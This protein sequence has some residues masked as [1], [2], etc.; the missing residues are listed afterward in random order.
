MI[1]AHR[2]ELGAQLADAFVHRCHHRQSLAT[3]LGQVDRRLREPRLWGLQRDV[4]GVVREVEEERLLG[5]GGTAIEEGQGGFGL[6]DHA[7]TIVGHEV[8]RVGERL[9]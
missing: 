1:L 8:W 4:W 9:P 2:L 6:H 7:E 5:L 3:F